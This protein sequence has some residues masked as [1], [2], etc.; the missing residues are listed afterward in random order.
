MDA[1]ARDRTTPTAH[2]AP[3]VWRALAATLTALGGLTPAPAQTTD[4]PL[5]ERLSDT[6]LYAP[7]S[8]TQLQSDVLTFT[9]QY[10]LWSDGADKRRWIRLPANTAIDASLAD[11]WQFPPGTQLWKEFAYGTRR[12]ET[13]YI[14]RQ[15][16][17][18]WR[19]AS[20]VWD[21]RGHEA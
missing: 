16:N 12:V 10:P 2:A 17:G 8:T 3:S 14:E 18:R 6:N 1:R 20:Y 11:A 9:P 4:D 7:G 5:P 21:E 19:F 13:R 15:R